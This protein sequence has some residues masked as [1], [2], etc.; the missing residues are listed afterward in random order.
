MAIAGGPDYPASSLVG[1]NISVMGYVVRSTT[2]LSELMPSVRRAVGSVD[3]QLA[4]AQVRTLQ[5]MLDQP[6]AV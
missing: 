3:P 5:N 6:A 4:L 1:S 2:S